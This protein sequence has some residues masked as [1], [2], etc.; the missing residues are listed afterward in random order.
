M[1]PAAA[2]LRQCALAP[3]HR[4][5]QAPFCSHRNREG[6]VPASQRLLAS[7][8]SGGRD[9]VGAADGG[10][11]MVVTD[12]PG[13]GTPAWPALLHPQPP[14]WE[15]HACRCCWCTTKASFLSAPE[16]FG[17]TQIVRDDGHFGD[18]DQPYGD[19]RVAGQ[20]Y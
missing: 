16:V 9:T 2:R 7:E 10:A 20:A 13:T 4:M 8:R 18:D 17:G 5:N 12:G 15:R 3:G 19:V 11:L 6:R 1:K 14:A